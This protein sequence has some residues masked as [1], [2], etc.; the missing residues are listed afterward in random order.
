[1]APAAFLSASPLLSLLYPAD[2]SLCLAYR[3]A[4]GPLHM[5]LPS[6]CPALPPDPGMAC[7]LGSF[8]TLLE[9]FLHREAFSGLLKTSPPL[10]FSLALV[11]MGEYLRFY[12]SSLMSNFAPRLVFSFAWCLGQGWALSRS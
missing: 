1:M 9:C 12:L 5:L 6:A 11:I 10:F 3:L 2:C 4:P 8:R 7:S